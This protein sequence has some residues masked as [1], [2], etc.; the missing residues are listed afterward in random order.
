MDISQ[1]QIIDNNKI[2]ESSAP[3]TSNPANNINDVPIHSDE[4]R[5]IDRISNLNQH[6]VPGISNIPAINS[7]VNS[8]NSSSSAVKRGSFSISGLFYYELSLHCIYS[9]KSICF[10][11]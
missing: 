7:V 9:F 10:L 5:S 2:S 6:D 8:P 11:F 3:L 1:S 4:T